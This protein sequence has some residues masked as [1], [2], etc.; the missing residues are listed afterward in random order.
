[1]AE[2]ATHISFGDPD[3]LNGP[4]HALRIERAL[5]E[6]FPQI[7]FDATIKIQ[8][9]LEHATL[10]PG[11]AALRMSV[12]HHRGR[13]RRTTRS[14]GILPRITRRGLRAGGCADARRRDCARADL[15]GVHAMDDAR[16]YVAMLER[17]LELQL[18]ESVPSGA[19]RDPLARS[20]KARGFS[21]CRDS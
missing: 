2:G 18:V 6:S 8:H 21:N 7:T 11:A 16:G 19:A 13:G 17:I 12:H 15:R 5:H 14:F 10:P 9:I 3:F 20:R 4:T 1:V